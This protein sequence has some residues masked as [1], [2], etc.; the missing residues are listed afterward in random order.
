MVKRIRGIGISA[1]DRRRAKKYT[2][3]DLLIDMEL[4]LYSIF[5]AEQIQDTELK[6]SGKKDFGKTQRALLWQAYSC[7]DKKN[8]DVGMKEK[9]E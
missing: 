3:E 1:S 9:E 8:S 5:K 2:R 7:Y 6:E 4:Y